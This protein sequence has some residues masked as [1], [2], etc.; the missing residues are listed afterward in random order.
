MYLD[1]NTVTIKAK[2]TD[3]IIKF[4]LPISSATFAAIVEEIGK[5]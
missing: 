2:Y 4:S 5:G 1:E 3:D